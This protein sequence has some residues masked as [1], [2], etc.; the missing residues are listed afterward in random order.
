MVYDTFTKHF[1]ESA[2]T[3]ILD[4][5]TNAV[6]IG[7]DLFQSFFNYSCNLALHMWLENKSSFFIG[8][9]NF[10]F[11]VHHSKHVDTKIEEL[12]SNEPKSKCARLGAPTMES[13]GFIRFTHQSI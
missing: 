7:F 8:Y 11:P 5:N 2:L 13:G 10:P 3:K 12:F 6:P 9:E 4:D 1:F